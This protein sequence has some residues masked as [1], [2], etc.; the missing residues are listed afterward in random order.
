MRTNSL[1]KSLGD[2]ET[3]SAGTYPAGFP[4]STQVT[5][6]GHYADSRFAVE[7]R[8]AD[9]RKRRSSRST[10]GT[11]RRPTV[12]RTD[13]PRTPV[14]LPAP[15]SRPARIQPTCL[16]AQCGR[17]PPCF[18]RAVPSNVPRQP[19]PRTLPPN[20]RQAM[21]DAE[22]VAQQPLQAVRSGVTAPQSPSSLESPVVPLMRRRRALQD[23]AG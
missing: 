23:D 2:R 19:V 4:R 14:D 20:S 16:L 21:R 1:Y 12:V 18:Y 17:R 15:V 6:S 13:A 9:F 22:F 10:F 8:V 3:R 7:N 5:R 11:E